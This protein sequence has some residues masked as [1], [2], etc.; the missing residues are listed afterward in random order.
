MSVFAGFIKEKLEKAMK[1]MDEN[2]TQFVDNPTKDFTRNRKLTFID[3]LDFILSCGIKSLNNEI[4]EYFDHKKKLFTSSGFIQQRNKLKLNVIEIL[5]KKFM[6]EIPLSNKY[7]G[8]RL[9][10]VD[11]SDLLIPRNNKDESTYYKN[12]TNSKGYNM[13]HV[14]ALYDLLNNVYLGIDIQGSKEH[15]ERK[16]LITMLHR[17]NQKEKPLLIADRGFEGYNVFAH[18]IEA[19]WKFLIRVKDSGTRCIFNSLI[20]DR[21][22]EID[23]EFK[24]VLTK[25]KTNFIKA[26]PKIYKYQPQH[27][28]F[29]FYDKNGKY[30]IEFRIVKIKLADGKY[31]SFIT[32]LDKEEFNLT[33]ISKL[34]HMRWGIENSFRD[35]KHKIGL[36]YLHSK[37]VK[38]ITQEIFAKA[39]IYN[40]SAL[41]TSKAEIKS[42]KRKYEYKINFSTAIDICK[43]IYKASDESMVSKLFILIS[44]YI[45]PIRNNRSYE[46][47]IKPQSF[48]SFYYRAS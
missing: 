6:E 19:N 42:S 12:S 7:K 25:R 11:G 29:D 40:Y 34:Y 47:N 17:F 30:K 38:H 39:I 13:L 45:S 22:S 31:Q 27:V 36:T 48:V 28:N 18:L 43:R 15:H 44:S 35:L 1:W 26:N 3:T 46:R 9:L 41:I 32:N 8:Y 37:D 23:E 21:N 24:L 4:L 20:S 16:S 5:F 14:N 33:E 10:A 2:K